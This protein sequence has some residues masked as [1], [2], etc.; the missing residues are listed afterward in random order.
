MTVQVIAMH[1]WAG[2]SRGWEPFAAAAAARGWRWT[3]PDRGYGAVEPRT[4]PWEAQASRRVVI[5]HS[6]GPHLLAP[7]LLAQADAV[8]LLASFGQF[9]PGG[10]EGRRLQTA[11]AGMAEALQGPQAEAMLRTFL[12]EAAAPAPVSALPCTILDGP[13][14]GGGRERLR[15]DLALLERCR[16]LPEALAPG[17]PC[18]IVE[19]G[20]DR[21]VGTEVRELLRRERPDATVIH[22]PDAGHCLLNTPLLADLTAWIASL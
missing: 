3:M 22:Y 11:L 6:L 17:L 18:L 7:E 19:A 13:L 9:I 1:G 10:Q 20:A 21:I 15:A 4:V 5:G 8:V 2:D 16:Q 14:S 12:A